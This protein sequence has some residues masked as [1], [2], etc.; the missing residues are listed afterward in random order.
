[1]HRDQPIEP[2]RALVAPLHQQLLTDTAPLEYWDCDIIEEGGEERF[3]SVV[4]EIR[5]ACVTL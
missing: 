5:Q 1:M 4:D 2:P 3:R